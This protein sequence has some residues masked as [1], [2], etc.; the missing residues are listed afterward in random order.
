MSLHEQQLGK[1]VWQ[2]D[3]A[4]LTPAK[5]GASSKLREHD[6]LFL[7]RTPLPKHAQ[8]CLSILQN[9]P[10]GMLAI[11]SKRASLKQDKESAVT[12]RVD[13]SKLTDLER[14]LSGQDRAPMHCYFFES[15]T[16]MIREY[17]AIRNLESFQM[18]PLILDPLN[19]NRDNPLALNSRM[20][21]FLQTNARLFNL[22]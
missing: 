20:A 12:L 18:A 6:I 21:A 4:N 22:S 13:A 5:V 14:F 10:D 15:L 2:A 3:I 9:S 11:V 1:A 16:T 19:A 8:V 17:K 7:S